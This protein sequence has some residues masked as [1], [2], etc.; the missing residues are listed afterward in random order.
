M[1]P[2]RAFLA[3]NWKMH[4]S[5]T[6]AQALASEVIAMYR[7]EITVPV[8]VVLCVPSPYLAHVS[9]LVKP[10]L[11]VG[12]QNLHESEKGAFTGEVS[13][14]MLKSCGAT[15]VI[16]GHSERRL[17]FGESDERLK[18]KLR[19]AL[20]SGLRPIYC[21]GETREERA[22]G[23]HESVVTRQMHAALE[24]LRPGDEVVWAYEPVWAIGTGQNASPADA[25]AMHA[26][27]RAVLHERLGDSAERIPLL[28]G[29][30]LNADNAQALFS[31]PDVDGGLV[32]GASLNAR[33]FINILKALLEC[34]G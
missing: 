9:H 33:S 2:E 13:A 8:P 25:Q 28:Y 30:S 6:G 32:G 23:T 27:V 5:L 19:R 7:N 20:D 14:E 4:L 17:L 15:H 34:R 18:S 12:G 3:A 22:S 16:V 26:V 31:M 21:V 24:V 1:K 10:T 11:F 29:G